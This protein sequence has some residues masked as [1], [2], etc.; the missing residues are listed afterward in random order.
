VKTGELFI[1]Q[2]L[3]GAVMLLAAGLPW[4]PEIL[5]LVRGP[6]ALL[7]LG[8]GAALVGAAYL[9]GILGDRLAD[10]LTEEIERHQRVRFALTRVLAAAGPARRLP[11]LSGSGWD[12][13]FPEDRL[14]MA[15]LREAPA[16]VQWM[17]YHRSRVRVTRALA[18]WLPAVTLS[19][20]VGVARLSPVTTVAANVAWVLAPCVVYA[21]VAWQV[22]RRYAGHDARSAVPGRGWPRAPRT[23]SPAA[24]DYGVA[25]G[26]G[27]DSRSSRERRRRTLRRVL[28][29]DPAVDGAMVLIALSL[30]LTCVP[31]FLAAA[32]AVALAGGV[33]TLLS[34]WSWWRISWTF[35]AYLLQAGSSAVSFEHAD[36]RGNE[37]AHR[38]R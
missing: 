4:T 31:P 18:V 5:R 25:N 20:V 8:G 29:D 33:L 28:L 37:A 16:V 23:D 10:T 2:V 21:A 3:I 34:S 17:D 32:N 38:A 35:R 11:P 36:Q 14:R 1:E 30:G 6:D 15:V 24:Y 26:F 9:L 19:G 27:D 7:G 13:P 22:S 12:D